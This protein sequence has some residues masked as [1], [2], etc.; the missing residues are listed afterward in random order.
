MVIPQGKYLSGTLVLKSNIDFHLEKGA[1]L[2]SSLNQED[3]MDFAKLFEDDNACT[4]WDGGCFLFAC[5]EE[6]IT[7]SGEGVIHGQGDK[8]FID[9]DVDGGAHE[10][11]LSVTAFRPRTTFLEDVT[12]LTVRD[13][14]IQ[15]A[16]FWTLHMA[17]C[18]HVR[19]QIL[20]YLTMSEGQTMTV[21]ILTAARMF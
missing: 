20:R 11:P 10:C 3:I 16:A 13:I 8:V 9:D 12:N 4:G 6:N 7:I 19:V 15:D 18:H 2:I 17:G 21:L 1:V 14:T 5:H